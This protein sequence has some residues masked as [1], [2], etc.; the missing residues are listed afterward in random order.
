MV[1]GWL[2][3]PTPYRYETMRTKNASFP[4]RISRFTGAAEFLTLADGWV[5]TGEA[6]SAVAV[7]LELAPAELSR[8]A[9]T[10]QIDGLGW[11]RIKIHN[12]ND[13]SI[14]EIVVTVTVVG[15]DDNPVV[16]RDYRL[17]S[18][19]GGSLRV[20]EFVDDAGIRLTDGQRLNWQLKSA[21]RR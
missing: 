8:L 2:V 15:T 19:D 5:P 11:L 21:T 9:G 20:S 10:A 18:G 7:P 13:F 6:Q 4:V 1:L 16:S 17:A 3:W 12:G 14:A